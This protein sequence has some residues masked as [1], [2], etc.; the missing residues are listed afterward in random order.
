MKTQLKVLLAIAALTFSASFAQAGFLDELRKFMG[1]K[2]Q[3]QI[4]TGTATYV[5]TSG[6]FG[7]NFLVEGKEK[8]KAAAEVQRQC[9]AAG[10]SWVFCSPSCHVKN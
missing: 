9:N 4:L 10:V 3:V 8:D 5:C 1:I 6:A 2:D 7:R